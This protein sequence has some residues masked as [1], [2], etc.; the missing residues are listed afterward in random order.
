MQHIIAVLKPHLVEIMASEDIATGEDFYLHRCIDQKTPQ[1]SS[2]Y[3]QAPRHLTSL[4]YGP[5]GACISVLMNM[6]GCPWFDLTYVLYRN[7][8]LDKP[9]ARSENRNPLPTLYHCYE[10]RMCGAILAHDQRQRQEARMS[11]FL[12]FCHWSQQWHRVNVNILLCL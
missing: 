6:L 12:I 7:I 3:V 4:W 10:Y 8:L 11:W 2:F 9:S 5:K 1:L